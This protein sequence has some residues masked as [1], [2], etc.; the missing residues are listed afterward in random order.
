MKRHSN[1]KGFTLIELLAVLAII[2]ILMGLV[3]TAA[4]QSRQRAYK[5]K[6][7][8]ETQQ[9][10]AAFK[11]Y[12]IA[13]GKWPISAGGGYRDLT[14]SLMVEL[15]GEGPS[16]VVYLDVPA[17]AFDDDTFVDPWGN[18]YKVKIEAVETPQSVDVYECAI[19]F[20]NHFRNYYDDTVWA[21]AYGETD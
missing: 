2:G 11:S 18:P 14:K 10:A 13:N 1:G 3:G 12:W 4:Q 9:I 7:G 19:S 17:D 20:P 15:L 5:A 8:A 6:A 16:G 21:D